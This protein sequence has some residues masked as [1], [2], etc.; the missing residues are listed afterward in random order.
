MANEN[1]HSP[2][3]RTPHHWDGR[4][5]G[6]GSEFRRWHSVI[7]TVQ[8]TP[9]AAVLGFACDEGARRNGCRHGAAEG[10]HV[11]REALANLPVHN[12][13]PR[14]DAGTVTVNG[15]DMEGAQEELFERIKD[16]VNAGHLPVVLGGSHEVGYASY[17]GLHK[18]LQRPI[19]IVNFDGHL[20][21]RQTEI[22]THG[23]PFTQ[24][25]EM[26]GDDFDYS[27]IGVSTADNTG[28]LFNFAEELGTKIVLDDEIHNMTPREAAERALEISDVHD[29]L[30]VTI[31]LD[32][33]SPAVAPGV[34]SPCTVGIGIEPMRAMCKALAA[35][36][37]LRLVDVAEM[38]PYYDVDGRT[39]RVAARLLDDM[40]NEHAKLQ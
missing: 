23:T 38:N 32:A 6:D 17:L 29:D 26:V 25:A 20:D 24:V 14:Y 2:V 4:H 39:A 1:S 40:I 16:L 7:D 33:I 12:D 5:D 18:A 30:Y 19:S 9:G 34:S 31:D 37:K 15:T 11:L 21:L 35:T 22:P 8:N 36:G 27:V 13:L 3:S 10:P 28:K